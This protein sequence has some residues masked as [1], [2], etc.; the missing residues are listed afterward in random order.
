MFN[1]ICTTVLRV[2]VWSLILLATSGIMFMIYAMIFEGVRVDF[3]PG[4]RDWE[5]NFIKHSY[6]DY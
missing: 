6:L 4:D 5:T 3:A 2:Y 1:K